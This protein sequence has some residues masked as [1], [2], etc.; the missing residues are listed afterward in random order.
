MRSHQKQNVYGHAL[1][2]FIFPSF[3]RLIFA[4]L[5]IRS[6]ISGVVE[7]LVAEVPVDPIES[8]TLSRREYLGSGA[9]SDFLGSG[10]GGGWGV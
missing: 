10:F 3:S 8:L 5:R 6:A 9:R 1:Y 4:I 7:S 2:F